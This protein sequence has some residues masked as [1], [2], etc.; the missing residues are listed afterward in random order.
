MVINP[1][2]GVYIPIKELSGFVGWETLELRHFL[3]I[4]R[5]KGTRIKKNGMRLARCHFWWLILQRFLHGNV[6]MYPVDKKK[7]NV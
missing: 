4:L 2:V 6:D 5:E 3:P 7:G 1:I